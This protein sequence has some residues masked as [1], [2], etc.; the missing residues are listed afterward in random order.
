MEIH[1]GDAE[2]VK[3]LL[4]DKRPVLMLYHM[5]LCPHCQILKPT[6]EK[7]K[8]KLKSGDGLQVVEVEYSNMSA[9]PSHLRQIRGFPTIQMIEH[10]K[11]KQEYFGD[12]SMDSIIDFASSHAKKDKETSKPKVATKKKKIAVNKA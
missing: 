7:V 6:W 10:G 9:L 1:A 3:K 2:S 11:V 4:K 8:R 12:R 5:N